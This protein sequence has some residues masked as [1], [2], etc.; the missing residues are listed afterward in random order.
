MMP[1]RG[2]CSGPCSTP[3]ATEFAASGAARSAVAA[4]TEGRTNGAEALP[5]FPFTDRRHERLFRHLRT[6]LHGADREGRLFAA[7]VLR[8]LPTREFPPLAA[9]GATRA[10]CAGGEARVAAPPVHVHPESTSRD[11]SEEG[12]AS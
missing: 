2:E 1:S 7:R 6:L 12:G 10:T 9:R 5:F 8:R 3:P 4:V 11:V